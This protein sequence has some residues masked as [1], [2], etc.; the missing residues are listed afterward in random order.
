MEMEV[1]EDRKSSITQV[2]G[3]FDRDV[4]RCYVIPECLK[5]SSMFMTQQFIEWLSKIAGVIDETRVAFAHLVYAG[6]GGPG[7]HF[8][9]VVNMC[10]GPYLPIETRLRNEHIATKDELRALRRYG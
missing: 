7:V 4:L 2:N 8:I 5:L 10:L 1:N 6:V 3:E 9:I